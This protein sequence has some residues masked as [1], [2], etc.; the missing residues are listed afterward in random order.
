MQLQQSHIFLI[1]IFR[2]NAIMNQMFVA[3]KKCI[4]L[5]AI[6]YIIASEN[7]TLAV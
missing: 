4:Q 2:E 7:F 5:Q 6:L 1:E 3:S